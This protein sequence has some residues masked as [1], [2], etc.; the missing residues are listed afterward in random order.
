MNP[1]V[2]SAPPIARGRSTRAMTRIARNSSIGQ[3]PVQE[4]HNPETETGPSRNEPGP[5]KQSQFDGVIESL[6]RSTLGKRSRSRRGAPGDVR[7][8]LAPERALTG[9]EAQEINFE[10][11][12]RGYAFVRNDKMEVDKDCEQ[13]GQ[14]VG[15]TSA[16]E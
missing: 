11:R 7:Q 13:S 8:I 3:S 14:I 6:G 4:C 9:E 12:P 16:F 10:I 15:G 5:S 1:S 2:K